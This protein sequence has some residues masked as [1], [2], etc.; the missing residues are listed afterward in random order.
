MP[1]TARLPKR[2]RRQQTKKGQPKLPGVFAWWTYLH[3]PGKYFA[4]IVPGA[5]RK[6]A[7]MVLGA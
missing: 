4:G 6:L 5:Q 3:D 1:K 2:P 7:T